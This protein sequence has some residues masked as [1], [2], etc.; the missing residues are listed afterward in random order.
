MAARGYAPPQQLRL[1]Q[2]Y[3]PPLL[4]PRLLPCLAALTLLGTLFTTCGRDTSSPLTLA[5]EHQ[6]LCGNCHLA[7]APQDIPKSVWIGSVLP[8]MAARVGLAYGDYDPFKGLGM[9]EGFRVSMSGA[10]PEVAQVDS[11]LWWRVHDYIVAL[12][13]D[14]IQV[15]A[16]RAGRHTSMTQFRPRSLRLDSNDRAF[17]T[18]AHFSPLHQSMVVSDVTGALFAVPSGKTL[19][20]RGTGAVVGFTERRTDTLVTVIGGMNPS[21]IPTG[22]VYFQRG[23]RQTLVA[24][25]L[26]RPVFAK[27]LDFD[28]DGL[29]EVVVCEFGYYTG[30]LSILVPKGSAYES[31]TLLALPGTIKF[32]VLDLDGDGHLDIVV[33]ASQ[34]AEGIYALYGDGKLGFRTEAL[35]RL[36]PHYGSSWFEFVDMD[37]DSDKDIILANGDNADYSVFAKPYHGLRIFSD[38]GKQNFQESYFFPMYGCTR[39]AA[40]DYDGDGDIDLAVTAFFADYLRNPSEGFVVLN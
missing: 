26:H 40:A 30:A 6:Q 11:A 16:S 1:H 32:E 21:E 7:P 3:L 29:E 9:E 8:N 24:D 20:T 35:V 25:Q 17:I 31:K 13:P 38:E 2:P 34:G 36:P 23:G 10:Y 12:A 19:P 14:S 15:D 37:G 27:A 39:V 18:G 22:S 4:R 33:L 28:G 5:E